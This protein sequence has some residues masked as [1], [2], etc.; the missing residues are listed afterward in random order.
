MKN[1]ATLMSGW[2]NV[3]PDRLALVVA[4]R[5]RGSY[6]GLTYGDLDRQT[7]LLAAGLRDAGIEPGMRVALLVHP[8]RGMFEAGY[9]LLKAGAT[10]V[11][12]DGGLGRSRIAGCLD[13]AQ[14]AGFVGVPEAVL[15]RRI[16]GWAPSAE[17]VVVAGSDR[18]L[19]HPTMAQL[20]E[21]GKTLPSVTPA[22]GDHPAA[23]AFTSGSTGPPKGVEY[24][25]AMFMAQARMISS[26][27]DITPGEVNVATF[28]PFALL[29]PLMGMVTVLPRM[30]FTKPGSV[31]PERIIEVV[32]TFGAT[33]M[34]G[35]PALLDTVGRYGE[36]HG[37]RLPTL[38]RVLSA[39]A[40][41]RPDIARRFL[42]LLQ[43]CATIHTP[44]GATEALPVSSAEAR[45][46]L[47]LYGAEPARPGVCVGRP[48]SG[49][50]VAVIPISDGPVDEVTPLPVGEVGEIVVQGPVVSAR[51]H[52]RPDETR[53][54][55]VPWNGR[56]AHRMGD[57]G[58]FDDQGRLWFVGRRTHRVRTPGGELYPIP[59][60]G[61]FNT[62]PAVARSAL[63]GVGPS[64]TAQPVIVVQLVDGVRPSGEIVSQL[65]AVAAE[66]GIGD[67]LFHRRFPVDIRHN[68]KID[69]PAL[70]GW[71]SRKLAS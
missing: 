49:I 14:V 8:G 30:D 41:V 40:P 63:V 27:Y 69:R 48:V 70:A 60:E 1:A 12:V 4:Q 3:D 10:P 51:Y 32:S 52:G 23:I 59:T 64:D 15:A 58:Y 18:G 66:L 61:R 36:R 6:L 24:T 26:M 20:V 34:F 65:R 62:H 43:R 9:A 11:L 17:T 68:S 57:L 56:L 37:T 21:R 33:M 45:T 2:A 39:G 25:H 16:L 7:D 28:A 55:K 50:G 53:H 38:Q 54:A 29:G 13:E 67:V 31:D 71:A 47:D 35:S 42:G 5:R 22:A 46:L 19:G 44:Y